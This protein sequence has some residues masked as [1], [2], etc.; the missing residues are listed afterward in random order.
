MKGLVRTVILTLS[1]CAAT[2][3][4]AQMSFPLVSAPTLTETSDVILTVDLTDE[5]S[6]EAYAL[7][8][9]DSVDA[10]MLAIWPLRAIGLICYIFRSDAGDAGA[11]AARLAD[12]PRVITVEAVQ[13]YGTLTQTYSDELFPIQDAMHALRVAQAHERTTGAG[14]TVAVIDTGVDVKH[15]DLTAHEMTYRDFVRL[16][17]SQDAERH[18]TAIAALIGADASNG[19]G[20]VGIAPDATLLPLRACWEDEITGEGRCNSFTLA[21]ALNVALLE[22]ADVLNLSLGGPPDPLIERLV[23]QALQDGRIVVAA[24]GPGD[25]FPASMSGVIAVSDTPRSGHVT[26]PGKDI[27]SAAPGGGYDFFT[28]S[29][30]STAHVSGLAA[31]SLAARSNTGAPLDPLAF[32]TDACVATGSPCN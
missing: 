18:G 8:M 11:L 14:I 7:E 3:A 6:V 5:T 19:I 32:A 2:V 12:D 31:L 21:R 30:I 28:G 9:A 20:M 4:Q 22:E 10:E 17:D 24:G 25:P 26:A 15:P 27:L 16:D 23:R 29:S 1:L 13:G